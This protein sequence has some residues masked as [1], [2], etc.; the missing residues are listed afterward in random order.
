MHEELKGQNFQ[1]LRDTCIML[2]CYRLEVMP[3]SRAKLQ[4]WLLE[5]LNSKLAKEGVPPLADGTPICIASLQSSKVGVPL[6][7]DKQWMKTLVVDSSGAPCFAPENQL[8]DS[9]PGWL[10]EFNSGRH[11]VVYPGIS[12]TL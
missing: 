9:G 4:E 3:P 7:N 1:V 10:L 5:M 2:R 12:L 6:D 8:K 11:H